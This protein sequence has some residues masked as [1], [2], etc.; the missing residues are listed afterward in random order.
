MVSLKQLCDRFGSDKG[1]YIEHYERHFSQFREKPIRLLELG[2]HRGSSLLMWRE[3]FS[4]GHIVGV[5]IG[6]NP[7]ARNYDRVSFFQGSQGDSGFLE[8]V[9]ANVAPDGFDVVIDDAAHIAS[10]ARASYD[11]LVPHHLKPGGVYVVEDWGTGYWSTWPDG[12]GFSQVSCDADTSFGAGMVGFVKSLI[13]EVAWGDISHPSFGDSQVS[14]R[15]PMFSSMTI[16]QGVAFL[17]RS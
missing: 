8:G 3:Y 4:R 2:V 1:G 6:Q 12:K 5:D 13:D 17:T 16:Y 9:A 10:L 7:L 14:N 11:T 15:K